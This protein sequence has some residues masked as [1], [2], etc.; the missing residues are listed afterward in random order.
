[1]NNSM[2]R[3]LRTVTFVLIMVCSLK[4][5]AQ[6]ICYVD[7]NLILENMQDYK[8]SQEELD[9]LADKWRQEIAQEYD[10]IKGMYNRYQAEQ[11]LLSEDVKKQREEEITQK[12]K[13]V[14]DMQKDKF[15]PEGALF[16]RRQELV[17][18]I[19]DKVY[20]AIESYAVE[21]SY[22]FIFDKGG[23]AGIIFANSIF[24]K[25][26]DIQKRVGK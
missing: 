11:V 17:K 10:K 23:N 14:R 1:M 21:K 2:N 12:E 8:R 13:T 7:I 24:D 5:G 25:K 9:R 26:S 3:V 18:P 6:K 19:Q 20:S 15:G 16:K 4:V 22:D